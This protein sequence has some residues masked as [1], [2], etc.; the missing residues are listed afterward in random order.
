MGLRHKFAV[1]RFKLITFFGL[2]LALVACKSTNDPI[3]QLN[4]QQIA[5]Y[6]LTTKQLKELQTSKLDEELLLTHL[7][8]LS[9]DRFAGRKYLSQ[10][11]K[12]SQYYIAEQLKISGVLPYQGHYYHH[13][14]ADLNAQSYIGE[15]SQELDQMLKFGTNIIGWV[16]G[17]SENNQ[18]IVISA[19][20][21]HVGSIGNKVFNGADD[22]ASG[23]ATLI[24]LANAIAKNPLN[25]NVIVLFTDGEESNLLGSK[26]FAKNNKDVLK[27]LALN[28]NLDMIAG[29]SSTKTLRYLER[30]LSSSQTIEGQVVFKQI[31]QM[32]SIKVRKGF[33]QNQI[34]GANNG[35]A[36]QWIYASDHGVFYRHKVPFIYYG[37]GTHKNYHTENDTFGNVNKAFYLAASQHIYR[38]LLQ[39]DRHLVVKN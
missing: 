5:S 15:E 17:T 38:S 18:T 8:I 2:L 32:A 36:R 7:Q 23:T 33:K 35:S 24:E 34:R 37:V 14:D 19:H 11:S 9:S 30:G 3:S 6:Q 28:V 1:K 22:N 4:E 21:D 13:F 26:A 12:L 25:H 29:A 31:N 39:F 10:T 27:G 16:P 20:F